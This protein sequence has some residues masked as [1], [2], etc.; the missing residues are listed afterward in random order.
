MK[1][2]LT[3]AVVLAGSCLLASAGTAAAAT[4][5]P[6]KP[7]G[8]LQITHTGS[9]SIMHVKFV[10]TLPKVRQGEY[11]DYI[12]NVVTPPGEHCNRFG[13]DTKGLR[14]PKHTSTKWDP[15][16]GEEW[17]LDETPHWCGGDWYAQAVVKTKKNGAY[18]P[19]RVFARK[20]FTVG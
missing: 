13:F 14:Q 10:G 16:I 3:R 7:T 17:G 1:R 2:R 8:H 19:R 12:A 6:Y 4:P 15:L 5:P 11:V 20:S 18:V 9:T